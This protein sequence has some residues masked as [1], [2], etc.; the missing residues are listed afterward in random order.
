MALADSSAGRYESAAEY[1]MCSCCWPSSE[2]CCLRGPAM[3]KPCEPG[4]G[5]GVGLGLR[6][7]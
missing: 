4:A 7:G 3:S 5:G 1:E 2:S 6:L